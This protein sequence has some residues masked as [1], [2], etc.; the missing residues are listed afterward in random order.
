M[1]HDL[2]HFQ[3]RDEVAAHDRG[4]IF[5]LLNNSG[6][7]LPREMAYGMDLFDAHLMKAGHNNHRFLLSEQGTMLLGYGCYGP[8]QLS[9]R[10][11]LLHWLAVDRH[12]LHQG[13]GRQVE[14]AIVE[15]VRGLGGVKIFAQIS[16][17]DYHAIARTFYESIG[18]SFSATIPDYYGDKDDMLLYVKNV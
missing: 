17:R 14:S 3:I 12:W 13:L 9:D 4:K 2:K 7:F 6:L 11:Y 16:N 1:T 18:Y 10:R 8:I 5:N 15:R